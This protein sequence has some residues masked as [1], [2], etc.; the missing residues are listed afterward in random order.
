MWVPRV[1]ISK[2]EIVALLLRTEARL[3][4]VG[5]SVWNDFRSVLKAD[6]RLATNSAF[7]SLRPR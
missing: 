6:L 7:M 2:E 4:A 3:S 1:A 5:M